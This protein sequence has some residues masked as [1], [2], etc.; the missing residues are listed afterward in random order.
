MSRNTKRAF[1]II[2]LTVALAV[3]PIAQVVGQQKKTF[4]YELG[5]SMVELLVEQEAYEGASPAEIEGIREGIEQQLA[6]NPIR[7]TV[8]PDGTCVFLTNGQEHEFAYVRTGL[9]LKVKNAQTGELVELGFFSRDL[10]KLTI[11]NKYIL[12]LVE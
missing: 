6:E 12:D 8:K 4:V 10:K 2:A 5:R 11:M 1:G 7:V 3:M 9:K